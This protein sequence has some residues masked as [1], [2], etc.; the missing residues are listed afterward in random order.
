MHFKYSY[1]L[2][3]TTFETPQRISLVLLD[4]RGAEMHSSF[5]WVSGWTGEG[6]HGLEFSTESFF[7]SHYCSLPDGTSGS[8]ETSPSGCLDRQPPIANRWWNWALFFF[9]HMSETGPIQYFWIFVDNDSDILILDLPADKV[10]ELNR[11]GSRTD[12]NR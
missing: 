1:S 6:S 9:V 12:E 7:I 10:K 2:R 8:C 4:S 5:W 11:S 3:Y